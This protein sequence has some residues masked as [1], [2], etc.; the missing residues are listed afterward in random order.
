MPQHETAAP[1]GSPTREPDALPHIIIVGGGA[2]GLELATRLGDKL[3]RRRQ[4]AVTLV[5]RYPVHLWKP[6]LH[7][8]AAGTGGVADD[9]LEYLAQAHW[10]RFRFV[11]GA[12]EGLDR[13]RKE[14]LIAPLYDDDTG[15]EIS[16]RRTLR[17]DLLVIA[18]G[19][20]ANDFATPGAKDFAISLDTEYEAQ[21]FHKRLLNAFIRAHFHVEKQIPPPVDVAIIGAGATGIEL[22]A[23]LHYTARQLTAY[24]FDNI[25]P[26][27]DITLTVI[28]AAPRI[29][30]GLPERLSKATLAQVEKLGIRVLTGERVVK[31]TRAGVDTQSGHHIPASLVVWAAGIKAPDVLRNLD[32]LETN[33]LNQLVVR[34]SLQTCR[35]DDI[36]AFGDCAA[37]PWP[38]HDTP[39]PP[40]AQ[41]AHQQA[42][43]L[44]G[45]L[46]RRLRGEPLPDYVYRDFG[47]LVS[48]GK[49]STVGNLMGRIAGGSIMIEGLFARLMYLTLHKLHLV[50]LHGPVKVALA[51]V[52]RLIQRR[53]EPRIKLH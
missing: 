5:D 53:T 50:A 18:I 24:G 49:Y 11:L 12:L 52:G 40:R 37:C 46:Q 6:L 44:V 51:T 33:H 3:G 29:L 10:H 22:A 41:A 15:V 21:R 19:S 38:G 43:L 27:R 8:V 31:V 39:V 45:S 4:A 32:G 14:I 9:E 16:P 47:S 28:E 2:G 13:T 30:P 25:A 20:T 1:E 48:L 7:Q 35:D 42:N 34:R 23:E 36:F 26:E 17:Y